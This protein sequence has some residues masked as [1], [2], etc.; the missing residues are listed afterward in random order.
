MNSDKPS[1][2]DVD[3]THLLSARYSEGKISLLFEKH[4]PSELSHLH[5]NR[6]LDRIAPLPEK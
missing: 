6:E 1:L 4:S 2:D 5:S 3:V